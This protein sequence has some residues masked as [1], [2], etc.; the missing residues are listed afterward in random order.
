MHSGCLGGPAMSEF[1]VRRRR[2]RSSPMRSRRLGTL[3]TAAAGGAAAE[4][5]GRPMPDPE[6]S[7][8]FLLSNLVAFLLHGAAIG[9]IALAAY[10]VEPEVIEEIIEITRIPDQ[11][12]KE[13]SAPRPRVIAES[14]GAFNPAA[15]ALQ[16]RIVNPAVIQRRTNVEA[17]QAIKPRA[18]NIQAPKNIPRQQAQPM[19]QARAYQ[20]NVRVPTAQPV[21][22]QRGPVLAGPVEP[23]L[24]AGT[25]SGPRRIVTGTTAGVAG[26]QALGTGSSV[27]EGIAS[28]RD[29]LGAKTGRR[30]DANWAVGSLGDGRGS[31]GNG[32]GPGGVSFGDCMARPE[33]AAYLD[34]VRNRTRDRWN[35]PDTGT[36]IVNVKLRFRLDPAGPRRTSPS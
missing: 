18:V 15:Q 16:P 7:R 11:P 29:V 4:F 21:Q 34:R 19:A 12:K 30:A 26:A 31:G 36:G 14:A 8:G 33:V 24:Q 13:E 35:A 17:A 27:R 22:V 23:Q 20:S 25:T 9:G 10:L 32:T 1:V 5:P 6:S 2:R 28:D 3:A